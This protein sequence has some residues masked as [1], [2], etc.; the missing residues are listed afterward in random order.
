[1][2]NWKIEDLQRG[3]ELKNN[4]GWKVAEFVKKSDMD[5][6]K[7]FVIARDLKTG[8]SKRLKLTLNQLQVRYPKLNNEWV[9]PYCLNAKAG[10]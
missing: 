2:T 7:Y 1:M 3:T 8:E 6:T 10:A 5:S 9:N 4:N